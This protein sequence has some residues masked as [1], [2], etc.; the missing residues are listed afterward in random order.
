MESTILLEPRYVVTD[1]T[2]LTTFTPAQREVIVQ[3]SH[4]FE[5]F[6]LTAFSQMAE[7][8][9]TFEVDI[10]S[11]PPEIF[12]NFPNKYQSIGRKVL[13]QF[14]LVKQKL[15]DHSV[16]QWWISTLEKEQ[17][18][19]FSL[20]GNKWKLDIVFGFH[21]LHERDTILDQIEEMFLSG[22]NA[23]CYLGNILN[24]FPNQILQIRY[25]PKEGTAF[26]CNQ[27]ELATAH[28][29]GTPMYF[30]LDVTDSYVCCDDTQFFDTVPVFQDYDNW[31]PAHILLEDFLKN[32]VLKSPLDLIVILNKMGFHAPYYLLTDE[33]SMTILDADDHDVT[34]SFFGNFMFIQLQGDDFAYEYSISTTGPSFHLRLENPHVAYMM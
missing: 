18:I 9:H 34:I 10:Q 11:L 15:I 26:H 33:D 25:I 7:I 2:A 1:V 31:I 17:Q 14:D 20:A 24:A 3:D 4:A 16:L 8:F 13:S 32:S 19:R 29:I 5:V 21:T 6:G 22:E 27:R 23:H 12:V 30:R 28:F